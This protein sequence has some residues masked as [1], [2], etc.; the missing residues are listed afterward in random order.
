MNQIM[1]SNGAITLVD[2]IDFPNLSKFK[3]HA[4]LKHSGFYARRNNPTGSG[5]SMLL[6]HREIMGN[7]G[8]LVDHRNGNTLDNRRENLRLASFAQN[9][10]NR[11]VF[12]NTSGF[13]G[14][15]FQPYTQK[16]GKRAKRSK[17]WRASICSDKRHICIGYYSSAE[18]AAAAYDIAAA[19]YHGEFAR[20]NESLGLIRVANPVGDL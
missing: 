7:P 6:M 3:W 13:K 8:C 1:L 18:E 12:E 20:T 2:D 19:K 17:P 5:P 14:V 10:A 11:H 4:S 16:T 9:S 15:S